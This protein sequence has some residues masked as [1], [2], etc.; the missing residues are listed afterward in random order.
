MVQ[1]TGGAR[2]KTRQIFRRRAHEKGKLSIRSFMQT[3]TLGQKVLLKANTSY[4][5][6]MYFR[7]FHSKIGEVK[8]KRG[9]CYEVAIK[10]GGKTKI[11]L[12][13]PVHLVKCQK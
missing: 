4:Q 10:D 3:F 6:G 11:M 8:G 12:V 7:R 13:H 1:H 5:K 9:L 2:R